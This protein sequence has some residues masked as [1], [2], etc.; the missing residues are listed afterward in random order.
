MSKIE[1]IEEFASHRPDS[2]GV[3]G[4][5]S[6]VFNQYGNQANS[7]NSLIDVIFIVDDI[8]EWHSENMILNREDYSML[9]RLHF[10][11]N[12]IEKLKGKN[13][14]TYLSSVCDNGLY[15][16]YGV[17]ESKDF[18]RNLNEWDNIFVV[19]RFQKPVLEVKSDDNIKSSIDYNRRCALMIACLFCDEVTTIYEIYKKLC[20]LSYYGDFRM[21]FAENPNKVSNI[22]RGSFD[23]LKKIYPLE[24]EYL[25]FMG[26]DRV[27]ISHRMILDKVFELPDAMLDFLRE[28]D[29]DFESLDLVRI[30][31][32]TFLMCKNRE[33]SKNQILEGVRTNGIVRSIPYALS[34]VKKRM[35]KR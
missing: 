26:D 15:F 5:G 6:K 7:S 18:V 35:F 29:T 19:G 22:V 34:K 30:N 10:N 16:K 14:I 4:Y 17:I 20:G 8:K 33:E 13:R 3:Y 25:S 21:A 24:E 31:I 28:V 11:R 32:A 9:G 23:T 1:I 12:N 27:Y 2:L